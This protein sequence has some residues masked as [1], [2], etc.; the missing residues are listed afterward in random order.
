MKT[1]LMISA[2]AVSL[3]ACAID[4]VGVEQNEVPAESDSDDPVHEK[5]SANAMSPDMLLATSIPV[6]KL[7]STYANNMAA[8]PEGR[9]V[10]HYL[11]G[12]AL[13]TN[14]SQAAT[15]LVNG[16]P[17]TTTYYGSV[18]LHTGWKAFSP[19]LTQQRVISSCMLSRMNEYGASLTISIRGSSYSLDTGETTNYRKQ[20]GAFFGNVFNGGDNYWGS[21]QGVDE[22]HPSR[23][24]AQ[25]GHCGMA[26]EGNCSSAC[27]G[28]ASNLSCTA[29][30]ITWPTA[31]VF[32][33]E[34]D[35]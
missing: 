4:E 18:G 2:L 29:N 8:T 33:N 13:G 19:T 25:D 15:Y 30:G 12:C 10:L 24:C 14:V 31:T 27:T 28:T 23:Q 11:I 7:T 34:A 5:L 6:G 20:E 26:W 32:L 9:H 3:N 1:A 22:T 35:Y 21:C 17:T 16:V